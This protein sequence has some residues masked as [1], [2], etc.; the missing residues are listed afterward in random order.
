MV[1]FF[2]SSAF[3]ISLMTLFFVFVLFSIQFA[4]SGCRFRI[5]KSKESTGRVVM[6]TLGIKYSYT[7]EVSGVLPFL[8]YEPFYYCASHIFLLT[9]LYRDHVFASLSQPAITCSKLTKETLE[10][11]VKY[12][13]RQWRCFGVFIV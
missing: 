9:L 11:N 12:I 8:F 10:Q 2:F 13:R 6:W 7:L 3:K 1:S 5:Q 4:F